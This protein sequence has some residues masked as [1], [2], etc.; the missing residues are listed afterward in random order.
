MAWCSSDLVGRVPRPAQCW[1]WLAVLR[2]RNS[3]RS[4]S[5]APTI[6]ASGLAYGGHPSGGRAA[7]GAQQRSHC[8]P[9]PAAARDGR[10]VLAKRLASGPDGVQ[11]VTLGPTATGGPL[12]S[13][14]LDDPLTTLLQHRCQAGAEAARSLDRPQ[15][16]ANNVTVREVEQLLVAGG[17]GAGGGVGEDPA[18]M[19]QSPWVNKP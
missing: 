3:A 17:V 15:A 9:L 2:P 10:A 16:T 1:I 18:E 8:L 13:A 5:G 12:G 19:G 4:S 7:P 6:S 14:H 11:R